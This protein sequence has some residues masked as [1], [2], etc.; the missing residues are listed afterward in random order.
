MEA[1]LGDVLSRFLAALPP[2]ERAWVESEPVDRQ[3]QMAGQWVLARPP[4]AGTVW[5][6]DRQQAAALRVLSTHRFV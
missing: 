3:Q 1:K 6:G 2:D 5:A 4:V